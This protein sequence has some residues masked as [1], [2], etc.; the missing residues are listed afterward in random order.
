MKTKPIALYF[1]KLLAA[2]IFISVSSHTLALPT[3]ATGDDTGDNK[4]P[5]WAVDSFGEIIGDGTNAN[6]VTDTNN[7]MADYPIYLSLPDNNPVS[8]ARAFSFDSGSM[9]SSIKPTVTCP[10]ATVDSSGTYSVTITL[11]AGASCALTITSPNSSTT[12]TAILSRTGNVYSVSAGTVCGGVFTCITPP[13]TPASLFDFDKP[14][15]V[16]GTEVTE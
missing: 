10:G 8:V 3:S 6:L 12:Y 9:A 15:V 5:F 13:P 2:I 7:Q 1:S 14:A 11:T 4:I 16:Y